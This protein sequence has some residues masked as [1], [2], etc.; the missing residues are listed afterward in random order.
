MGIEI[1]IS[2]RNST[3]YIYVA[4]DFRKKESSGT[5]VITQFTE[6]SKPEVAFSVVPRYIGPF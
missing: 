1:I 3:Y 6:L 5:T 4:Q 2:S